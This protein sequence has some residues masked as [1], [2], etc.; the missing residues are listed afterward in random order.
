MIGNAKKG[1]TVVSN[2][3]TKKVS[4]ASKGTNT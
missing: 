1:E 2:E 3:F 4:I